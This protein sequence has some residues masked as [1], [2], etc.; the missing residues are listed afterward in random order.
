MA[1]QK[2]KKKIQPVETNLRTKLEKF[3]DLER[4][5]QDPAYFMRNY[6]YIQHPTKGRLPFSLFPFQEECIQS[7]LEYKYNVVV[8]SRQLGLSTVTAAYC[9]WMAL[10]HRDRNILFMATKLDTAKNMISKIRVMVQELPSWMMEMLSLGEMEADSVRCLKLTNGSKIT[11]IPTSTDAGRGEAVSFLVIDEA[12][13]IDNLEE[14]WAGLK[15][16][17]STGGGCIVFSSPCGKNFFYDLYAGADTGVYKEGM[18]GTHCTTEGPNS[19]HAVSLPWTVH[20]E[21]DQAWYDHEAK[22]MNKRSILQELMCRFEGSTNT[23]FDQETIDWYKSTGIP[24]LGTSGPKGRGTDFWIWKAPD[25]NKTYLISADVA[26]GDSFDS[27]AFHVIDLAEG[28]VVA[29]Y[30]GKIP[31]DKYGEFLVEVGLSYNTAK[32]IQEK[33]SI[34]IATAIKLRD[35]KYPNL[36]YEGVDSAMYQFVEE[37][38]KLPGATTKNNNREELLSKLEE[39]L[40]NRKIKINSTRFSQQLEN[41]IWTGKRG[42]AINHKSDDLIMSLAVALNEWTPVDEETKALKA[43]QPGGLSPWHQAFLK[44]VRRSSLGY[45]SD[46][47]QSERRDNSRTYKG[48][49]LKPGVSRETVEQ[50]DRFMK[51]YEWVWRK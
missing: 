46:T 38:D 39:A 9:L 26:R 37:K 50:Q 31:P 29:E 27:S 18:I 17:L 44:S 40:R 45:Y 32:I 22:S 13:H 24:P 21:R 33:N 23:Y 51:E 15:P 7:F 30:F 1:F 10:F 11:A 41:F 36:Y 35:L 42:Q 20:P 6:V 16:M 34:G 25:P 49:P 28:E 12:A 43:A 4:C 48:I 19:F 8:K 3:K 5:I 47:K 14:L 2:K